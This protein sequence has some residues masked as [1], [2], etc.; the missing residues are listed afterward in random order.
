MSENQA[1]SGTPPTFDSTLASIRWRISRI[2]EVLAGSTI[3]VDPYDPG[4]HGP[5]ATFDGLEGYQEIERYW[6]NAPFAFV[7]IAHDPEAN[8]YRYLVVEPDLSE[9]EQDLLEQLFTDSR[10]S[11]IFRAEYAPDDAEAVITEHLLELL[12][13]YGADVSP[14]TVYRLFYYLYRS[15]EGYD[16][17]DPLMRDLHIEDISC[18]GYGLPLFVYHD[19]YTD[20]QGGPLVRRRRTR[21][22]RHQVGPELGPAHLDR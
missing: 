14:N 15:F 8:E 21:R 5:L 11:L 12:G 19:S 1:G 10:E 20:I 9:F 18:D 6:V 2:A 17:L 4:R 16:K 7:T 13:Q 22:F 3:D